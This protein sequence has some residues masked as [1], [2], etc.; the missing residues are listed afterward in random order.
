MEAPSRRDAIKCLLGTLIPDRLLFADQVES[1]P[2]PLNGTQQNGN[3]IFSPLLPREANL[4]MRRETP[5]WLAAIYESPFVGAD[6]STPVLTRWLCLAA[7]HSRQWVCPQVSCGVLQP[8]SAFHPVAVSLEIINGLIEVSEVK[9]RGNAVQRWAWTDG[10]WLLRA[11]STTAV[12]HDQF[13]IREY[14]AERCS[15]VVATGKIN[16][17][18]FDAVAHQ[19]P[20]SPIDLSQQ[21]SAALVW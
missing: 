7:A 21:A 2:I 15:L 11:S 10:Q 17:V 4:V 8:S 1:T 16:G 18:G 19:R 6:H 12:F 5:Q 9:L 3:A 14:N 20:S 13:T